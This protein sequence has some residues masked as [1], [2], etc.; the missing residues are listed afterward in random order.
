MLVFEKLSLRNNLKINKI[1][2]FLDL[3]WNFLHTGQD[4]SVGD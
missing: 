1:K 3:L 4:Q 2:V